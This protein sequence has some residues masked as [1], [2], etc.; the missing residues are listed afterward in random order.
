MS[1]NNQASTAVKAVL[2]LAIVVLVIGAVIWFIMSG[3]SARDTRPASTAERVQAP[4]ARQ[5]H[6]SMPTFALLQSAI[7]RHHRKSFENALTDESVERFRTDFSF[8]RT[9]KDLRFVAEKEQ[10]D[11]MYV[12]VKE[13]YRNG[14]QQDAVYVFVKERGIWKLDIASTMAHNANLQKEKAAKAAE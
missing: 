3:D 4:P 7:Q 8:G 5:L 10:G 13:V 2:I 14:R 11:F 9:L 1:T 12:N 6:S